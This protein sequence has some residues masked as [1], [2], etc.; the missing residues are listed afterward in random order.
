MQQGLDSKPRSKQTGGQQGSHTGLQGFGSHFGL[1][2][3]LG[4]VSHF[5]SQGFGQQSALG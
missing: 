4:F 1:V 3:G 2:N 5:G